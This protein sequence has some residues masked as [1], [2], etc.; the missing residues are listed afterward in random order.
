M[1]SY[2]RELVRFRPGVYRAHN[3]DLH[4]FG[5]ARLTAHFL[6]TGRKEPRIFG[7]VVQSHDRFSMKWLRGSGIEI[8][9][10]KMP[11]RLFGAA[12]AVQADTDPSLFFGGTHADS[13]FSLDDPHLSPTTLYDFSVASHVL[14]HVDSFIHELQNLIKFVRPGGTI[15]VALPIVEHLHDAAWM[16]DY[17]FQHHVDE[18]REPLRYADAHDQLI[19]DE[20][21]K[22][23]ETGFT[24]AKSDRFV[25]HKHNY[26]LEGW[27]MIIGQ[28]L[29]FLKWPARLVDCG[30][31]YE[32]ND[33]LFILRRAVG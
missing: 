7:H 26:T 4:G 21:A 32:R 6:I 30:Y 22:L 11:T 25:H 33:C 24:I 18:Y 20:H 28:T 8:G 2:C 13:I 12:D 14:E 23:Y 5:L 29:A 10:G 1:T 19:V 31:G 27:M 16:P 17:D 3:T 15:Y 9:A